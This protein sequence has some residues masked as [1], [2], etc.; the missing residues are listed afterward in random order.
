[1]ERP[2]E[3]RGVGDALQNLA[4]LLPNITLPSFD[5]F[6]KILIVVIVIV[7]LVIIGFLMWY[8]KT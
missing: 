4:G 6:K 3:G 5:M 2:V 1:L 8:F 7:V